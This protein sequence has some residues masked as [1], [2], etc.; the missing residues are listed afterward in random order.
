VE[1]GASDAQIEARYLL[2]DGQTIT[3]TYLQRRDHPRR[4][5]DLGGRRQRDGHAAP[6]MDVRSVT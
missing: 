1:R 6:L 3:K 2:P 4:A 5:G